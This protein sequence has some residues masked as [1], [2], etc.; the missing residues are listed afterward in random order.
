VELE[1]QFTVAAPID[2]AWG[3][4]N[5]LERI[6]PCFPGA[7]LTSYDGQ[8]F[9]GLVKVK[10]GPISLQYKGNGQFIERDVDAHRAV[11]EAKGKDRRGNGTAAANVTALLTPNGDRTDIR[12]TTDLAITGRPA[13]FGRGVMQDVS[14]K[15][16]GQFASCLE[17]KLATSA[18]TPAD[19]AAEPKVH[20]E[21]AAEPKADEEVATEP[22]AEEE[23]VFQP[24]A[25]AVE[26]TATSNEAP[27]SAGSSASETAARTPSATAP[28]PETAELDL[29]ATVLPVLLRRYAPHIVAGLAVLLLIRLV[30]RRR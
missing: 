7:A 22:K 26:S 15:L 3:A 10:L 27:S 24:T 23:A 4:F 21:A 5:D 6:A 25:A 30:R 19:T 12:V 17:Q 29:G 20:Q 1:H 8:A 18:E 16:L 2:V 28:E 14:N 9:E 13:Q 11:I